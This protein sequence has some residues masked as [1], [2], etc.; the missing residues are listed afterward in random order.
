M[1]FFDDV[2]QAA[3][4]RAQTLLLKHRVVVNIPETLPLM[5]IDVRALAEVIYTLLDNAR[6][7][8]PDNSE[9]TINA[10]RIERDVEVSVSDHGSGIQKDDLSKVFDKFYRGTDRSNSRLNSPGGL[11]VG[12]SIAKGLVEAHSGSIWIAE[13]IASKGTTITFRIPI[14]EDG[15]S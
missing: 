6:K 12:L 4:K 1:G 9:I 10:R 14:R 2:A 3:I 5:H 15:E 8:S 7:Y 11:G 13:T